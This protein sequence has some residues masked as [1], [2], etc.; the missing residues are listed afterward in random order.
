M[1]A[2]YRDKLVGDLTRDDVAVKVQEDFKDFGGDTLDKLDRYIA[3]CDAVVHLVGDM[4]GAPAGAR[5]QAA[6]LAKY[7]D[8]PERLPPLAPALKDGEGVPYTQW[9]AWLALFH[10][11]PLMIARAAEGAPRGPRYAPTE[12]AKAAQ[13]AHLKRLEA[14]GRY[15]CTFRNPDDLAT[16]IALGAILS[17]LVEAYASEAARARDVAE[18]FIREMAGKVALAK[19]LDLDGMKQAVRNALDI[20]ENEIAGGQT[21]TNTDT[22]VDA[23]LARA[24]AQVDKGQS[25]LARATLRL[26]AEEMRCEEEERRERYAADVTLLYRR[27]RDIALATYDGAAA[28]AAILELAQA[29]HAADAVSLV[30]FLEAESAS[31]HEYG[32]D[33]GSNVHLVAEIALRREV[34]SLARDPDVAGRARSFLGNALWTLGERESETARLEEAVE[35]YRAALEERLA[36]GFRSIG[37]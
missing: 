25:G 28:A 10:K 12:G 26:A 2:L 8:L 24:K 35:A 36:I 23:V 13:A 31:L 14:Y 20:Y 15:G 6:L 4:C 32:R 5:E 37:R 29:L 3:R 33:R 30:A 34:L 1:T 7:P 18:G 22:I 27:E 17:L 19:N 11:K 21:Q 16:H 9:E